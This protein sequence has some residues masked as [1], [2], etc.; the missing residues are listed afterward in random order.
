MK[1]FKIAGLILV[2]CAGLAQAEPVSKPDE[3]AGEREEAPKAVRVRPEAAEPDEAGRFVSL[4]RSSKSVFDAN[5]DLPEA[6]VTAGGE[7]KAVS[8]RPELGAIQ[9]TLSGA[10]AGPG[11]QEAPKLQAGAQGQRASLSALSETSKPAYGQLRALYGVP[12]TLEGQVLWGEELGSTYYLLAADGGS[13]DGG[14]VQAPLTVK[15]WNSRASLL[16]RG[17]LRLSSGAGLSLELEGSGRNRLWTRGPMPDPRMDRS[18]VGLA[19]AYDGPAGSWIRHRLRFSAER[20]LVV[21][22]GLGSAYTESLQGLELNFD[23][24]SGSAPRGM[25]WKADLS[26]FG[27]MQETAPGLPTGR[28]PLLG[29][30]RLIA[31]LDLWNGA[32]FGLGLNLEGV[33]GGPD[34]LL[35]APRFELEQRVGGGISVWARFDPRLSIPTLHGG[36]FEKDPALPSVTALPQKELLDLKAGLN[37]VFHDNISIELSGFLLENVDGTQLDDPFALG[38]WTTASVPGMRVAGVDFRQTARWGQGFK[39]G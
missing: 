11:D 31:H 22:P 8:K 9:D 1:P 14:P 5:Y 6:V 17:G 20:S 39:Q 33:S 7:R 4:T 13:S 26:A 24:P 15:N 19:L 34:V 21:L 18:R 3:L 25:Q 16:A 38:L 36:L 35:F 2:F 10:K 29:T 30:A 37:A 32:R 28:H 27:L 12:N 23:Q